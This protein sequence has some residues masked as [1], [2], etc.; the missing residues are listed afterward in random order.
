MGNLTILVDQRGN[1]FFL[2]ERLAALLAIDQ[3]A[4]IDLLAQHGLPEFGVG[5]WV[6]VLRF[7]QGR[8]LP[9]G[10]GWP[11]AS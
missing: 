4:A 7:E 5:G 11:I 3:G 8:G 9:L 1:D 10:T 6:L 2:E